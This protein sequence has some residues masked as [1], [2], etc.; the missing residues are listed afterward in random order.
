LSEK[1]IVK[2]FGPIKHVELDIKKVNV[3]IGEQGTGK[4]ALV[5]LLNYLTNKNFL[6]GNKNYRKKEFEDNF[7]FRSDFFFDFVSPDFKIKYNIKEGFNIEFIGKNHNNLQ[8]LSS[9]YKN[10]I[11]DHDLKYENEYYSLSD[12]FNENVIRDIYVPAERIAITTMDSWT[13]NRDYLDSYV[14]KFFGN[15]HNAREKITEFEIPH[16]NNVVYKRED[17]Q[18]KVIFNGEEILLRR[19]SSGFQSSI[20]L[21]IFVEYFASLKERIRFIIEEP[22]LNLFPTTQY[23]LMKFLIEKT[24][25]EKNGLFLAT[26]SP[27]ILASINNLLLVGKYGNDKVDEVIPKKYWLD[28]NDV[29]AYMLLPNGEA[30]DIIDKE[31]GQIKAEKIDGASQ[32]IGNEYEKI[33][34]ITYSQP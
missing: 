9:L 10:F 7:F 15:F 18:D 30:E 17:Q 31:S 23:E 5:K 27:Y 8:R 19:A 14:V 34:N 21:S 28:I 32:I 33:M 26:H 2:N 22:E 1:L 4:S 25:Q 24:S 12:W 16:L 11:E 3:L 6:F 20:P 29:S 13:S